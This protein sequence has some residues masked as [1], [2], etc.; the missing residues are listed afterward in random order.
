M[1]T[2]LVDRRGRI[3]E[4][5]TLNPAPPAR[6]RPKKRFT[7]IPGVWEELLGKK[8]ASGSTYAVAIVLLYEAWRLANRGYKPIVKLTDVMLKRVHVRRRGKRN[9][10]RKLEQLGLVAVEWRANRNPLVTVCFFDG[11]IG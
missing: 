8:H 11:A 6:K 1:T 9:A 5:E 3:I 4:V 10:L 7:Q 2:Q